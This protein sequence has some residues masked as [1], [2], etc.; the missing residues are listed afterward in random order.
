MAIG[1]TTDFDLAGFGTLEVRWIT[2]SWIRHHL[3]N[4]LQQLIHTGTG[5]RR[6]KAHR[7]KVSLTQCQL[8]RIVQPCRREILTLLQVRLHQFLVH[9]HHLV[10]DTGVRV[11]SIENIG[12]IS[13]RFEEAVNNVGPTTSRQVDG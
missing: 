5:L 7:D 9:L 6:H 3:G 12:R 2:F 1:C 13:G 11:G 10:D 8:E 4:Y